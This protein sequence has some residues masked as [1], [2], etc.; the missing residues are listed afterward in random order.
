[1][2][3]DHSKSVV[4]SV[5]KMLDVVVRGSEVQAAHSIPTEVDL[6]FK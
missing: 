6:A 4:D 2:S 1:L 3:G 5:E